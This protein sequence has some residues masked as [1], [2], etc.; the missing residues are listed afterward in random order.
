[1]TSYEGK[2][3]ILAVAGLLVGSFL[4]AFQP[5]GRAPEKVYDITAEGKFR[6]RLSKPLYESDQEKVAAA[7]RLRAKLEEAGVKLERVE[8]VAPKTVEVETLA[9]SEEERV[10]DEALLL[11][12]LK[13]EDPQ[14]QLLQM[15]QQ[16]EGRQPLATWGRIALYKPAPQLNWGL[17]LKGGQHL[18]LQCEPE[19]VLRFYTPEDKN[20]KITKPLCVMPGE[21]GEETSESEAQAAE[22][23]E[24]KKTE[25]EQEAATSWPKPT[26]TK[27]S[28]EDKLER[29]LKSNQ[30]KYNSVE[31]LAAN[32]IRITT[33]AE[34]AQEAERQFRLVRDWLR[35]KY[36]DAIEADD[37][38]S[39]FIQSDT[40]Q[41]VKEII[42]RR[43]YA[44][45][46]VK[47][48][49]IQTQ[50]NSRI[51][52]ELPGIKDPEAAL[53]IIGSTAV[54]EFRLVPKYYEVPA[55]GAEVDDY[56]E[57]LDTRKTPPQPVTEQSVL[58]ASEVKFTG[59][60]LKSNAAVSAGQKND[61]VVNFELKDRQ[62][63]AFHDF[64]RT[65]VG[66]IMAI[67]LD[68][69]VQMAPVIRSAIPGKGIIEGNMGVEEAKRLALLLNAGALP[70]HIDIAENR[71]VSATLG[72][73][74]IKKSAYAGLVGLIC[75]LIFMPAFYRLPGLLADASLAIYCL[76]TLALLVLAR[77]TM[78][79]PGIAGFILAIG[80][81]VDANVII[82]ERFKEELGTD[83]TLRSAVEAAFSRAWTAILDGNA[84][85]LIVA[86]VLWWLGTSLIKSFAVTLAIGVLCSMFTAVTVTRWFCQYLVTTKVGKNRRL[87]GATGES[88]VAEQ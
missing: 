71:T 82:F 30:I 85:T 21:E 88:E 35:E 1:M 60:D 15:E 39:T 76:L 49:V 26:E 33:S 58:D 44:Y 25:E 75:I 6:F 67:V 5:I 38:R 45:G 72:E 11:E 37:P 12:T 47:E 62:V 18:V 68:G 13:K 63:K 65:H 86:V 52:V 50:G 56:S 32:R 36:G 66:W 55:A 80:M 73:Y 9:L 51:I 41:K 79:L 19:T 23:A 7:N 14:V 31:V 59:T 57:W 64:T 54:L 42:D 28:L 8:M 83:K 43:L 78:T 24:S 77:T 4:I 20:G 84:T 70:V 34:N 69:K 53:R 74:S 22:K 3:W 81:A 48:P 40:A 2:T 46:K 16:K 10:A 27:A 29:L 87:F 61:W 17:D